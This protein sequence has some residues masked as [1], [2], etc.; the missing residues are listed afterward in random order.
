MILFIAFTSARSTIVSSSSR[1]YFCSLERLTF[2]LDS[3]LSSES[4]KISFSNSES[5]SAKISSILWKQRTE[6]EPMIYLNEQSSKCVHL[7]ITF[8][9][10]IDL[11]IFVILISRCFF[12]DCFCSLLT[13]Q[14]LSD[15]LQFLVS[16]F[17][18]ARN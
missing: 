9:F 11:F 4:I 14:C 2:C 5:E 8:L 12:I 6:R 1:M 3:F 16:D 7:R 15:V 13:C 17:I 18:V 10:Q